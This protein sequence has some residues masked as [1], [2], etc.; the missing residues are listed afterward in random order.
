[1]IK[2]EVI[3]RKWMGL[4]MWMNEI[5]TKVDKVVYEVDGIKK[6]DERDSNKR[7]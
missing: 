1:M 6:V 4:R 5:V 3:H 7:G 2:R